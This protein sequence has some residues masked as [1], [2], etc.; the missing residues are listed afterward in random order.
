MNLFELICEDDVFSLTCLVAILYIV[1]ANMANK[2]VR[3]WGWRA[4][5]VAYVFFVVYAIARLDHQLNER[6]VVLG[7]VIDGGSGIATI[8]HVVADSTFGCSG[9][10]RHEM[11]MTG[12]GF[13]DILLLRP[14]CR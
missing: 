14:K 2:K 10:S 12:S 1:G 9:C 7:V 11:I 6:A 13:G 4:A 8:D 3:L 5:A